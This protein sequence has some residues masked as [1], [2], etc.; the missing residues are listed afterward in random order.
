MADEL[1][2][3]VLRLILDDTSLKEGLKKAKSQIEGELGG[4]IQ[5]ATGRTPGGRGGRGGSGVSAELQASAKLLRLRNSINILE[6]N[7]VNVSQLRARLSNLESLAADKK[8]KALSQQGEALRQTVS[9][10]QNRLRVSTLVSRELE[11]QRKEQLRIAKE[12]A[13]PVSGVTRT[14]GLPS[15][16]YPG[17]PGIRGGRPPGG[18]GGGEP[19]IIPP[20]RLKLNEAWRK[21]FRDADQVRAAIEE[22]GKKAAAASKKS[23]AKL[24]REIAANALIGAGFP[25]LFGQGPGAAAGG[26]IGGG[27]GAL[28]GGTFGFAGSIAGTAIG[29][30][31]DTAL[32]KVQTLAKGLEDPI[33]NFSALQE[34]ALLSSRS[35]EKQVEALIAAGRTGEAYV[36]IQQDLADTFGDP[37]GARDYLK[38][39]DDLNREWAKATTTLAS[40]VAGPLAEFLQ[41]LRLAA[42]G[43]ARTA[44]ERAVKTQQQGSVAKALLAFGPQIA[45]LGGGLALTGAGAPVGLA[46]LGLG[47][48][49]TGIGANL[50]GGVGD[51]KDAQKILDSIP[52]AVAG[53][54]KLR[55]AR[56]RDLEIIRLSGQATIENL[57]GDKLRAAEAEKRRL[58]LERARA[59]ETAPSKERTQEIARIDKELA[60]NQAER[61]QLQQQNNVATY[62]ELEQRQQ[63]ERST[64]NT[65]Q[66]LG[67]QQ[68]QYRDTLRTVQ[69]ITASIEEGRRREASIGFQIGEAR[70][71]G[72]EEEAARLVDQQRTAAAETRQRLVEGALA[73]T[74]AGEK[75][76]NDVRDSALNLAKVRGG[77]GGLNRFLSSGLQQQ[78]AE[79]TNRLLQPFLGE[80][81]GRLRQLIPNVDLSSFQLGGATTADLNKNIIDFIQAVND[82]FNAT[83]NF[84]NAQQSL[85]QVNQALADINTQLVGATTALAQ[86]E[87]VVAVNVVNQAGG[88]STV[89]TVNGLS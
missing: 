44:E 52:A 71:A 16:Q 87:W 34:A 81:L 61:L 39:V 68:G 4:T 55:E 80:A 50:A 88:A 9:V 28:G 62:Q 56:E 67:V 70:V 49:I 89:N 8:Y 74:E 13:V 76:R 54:K 51:G 38:A 1:G 72:R 6:A 10:E 86:K 78:R 15:F 69:Q 35:L 41:R 75:L 22:S 57:Q 33:S 37:A 83:Q 58:E 84:A 27:L 48:A 82:E 46:G 20:N 36:L 73:L 64:A 79:Q 65:L 17:S 47:A 43:P 7:G 63:I 32:Q 40:F 53:A 30:A 45:A 85:L 24:N 18:G 2:T 12:N 19:P 59:V 5:K 77:E 25:L 42:G 23:A 11:K 26:A 21:F 60:A 31:F 3:A 29:A 14:P 66:L